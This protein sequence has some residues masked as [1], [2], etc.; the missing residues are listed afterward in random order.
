MM[1]QSLVCHHARDCEGDYKMEQYSL[2]DISVEFPKPKQNYCEIARENIV[3]YSAESSD[4][5]SLLAAIIGPKA[6]PEVCGLLASL[7]LKELANMTVSEFQQYEGIGRVAATNLVASFGIAQKMA[8][9]FNSSKE[10]KVVI[11]SPDDAA[12]LLMPKFRDQDQEH[13]HVLFLNTKNEVIGEKTIFIGSLNSA[14]VHPRE[15]FKEAIKR[16]SASIIVCHNHPSGN[17]R[18]SKEDVEVTRRLKKSGE[19]VGV[20]LLDHI[21]IGNNSYVSL[22]EKG[23]F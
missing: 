11:R 1:A 19:I 14:V 20:D 8:H 13:F 2:L 21:I 6:K 3:Y 15:V 4:L 18:E 9:S 16:S 17:P 12:Q 7:G 5:S 10:E 22:K 23:C